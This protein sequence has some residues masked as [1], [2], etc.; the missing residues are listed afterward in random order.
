MLEMWSRE[1]PT[2][3]RAALIHLPITVV[4]EPVAVLGGALGGAKR[5]PPE[6]QRAWTAIVTA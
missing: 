5:L 1:A 6:T 2:R 3:S 4:V